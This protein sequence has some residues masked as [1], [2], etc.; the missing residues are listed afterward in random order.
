IMRRA[1]WH[2]NK[3][4][5]KDLFLYK[6][7]GFVIDLFGETYPELRENRS[8]IERIVQKEEKSYASTVRVGLKVLEDV[9][10]KSS[11]QTISGADV[12]KL[13]DTYGLRL[14]MVEYVAEQQGFRIDKEGFEARREQQSLANRE[15]W[16]GGAAKVVN[17][18]YRK[19]E[20]RSLF[21]GYTGTDLAGA[22]VT[23]LIKDGE[24]VEQIAA[25]DEAEV[26]LERTPFYAES[27]GQV[28]DTGILENDI[29]RLLVS[30]TQSPASGVIAHKVTVE[31]GKL[32]VGDLVDAHVD[33]E[34]RARTMANHTATHLLHAALREVLGLHVKQAGSLVAP[35][36]LRF[37]FTH[38]A[39][40][41]QEE[42]SEIERIVNDETLKNTVVTKE[43]KAFDEAVQGGAMALFGEKYSDRVRV[44]SVP[45]F[46]SELC[47]GT[48]VNATGDI[49]VFK[50]ISDASIASGTRR[51]EAVTGKGAYER[52][53]Q[54]ES[55]LAEAAA[56]LNTSP[57]TLPGEVE[58]LQTQ[59]REQQREIERLKL[60]LAQGATAPADEKVI[61]IDGI[62]VLVRKVD[63]LGKDGRRQLADTLS[64]RIAP[65]VVILG[66]VSNGSA[67]LVV[68]VSKD[69]TGRVQAGN[70]IRELTALSGK[71]GGGKPDLAEGGALPEKL[72][73]TL[74]AAPAIIEKML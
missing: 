5:L 21:T 59:L 43:E 39:P 63:N 67:S 38:F 65:G 74:Q 69:A 72:D 4:G 73:E 16:K 7:A 25:G 48:H 1:I 31:Q 37:D 52:F 46:S 40:L 2:G 35:D 15:S 27:G 56:R 53:Q 10:K 60:K 45:G 18:S 61:E 47:G 6:V 66:E 57:R 64:K 54:S 11:E 24:T 22:K 3:V 30:D 28:G 20:G 19:I 51:I 23:G 14:D 29:A 8:N 58:R 49:G 55:L 12:F 13:Y 70:V 41:T 32:K 9:M 44:V 62:K 36:R 68:M 26:V 33:A 50:I 34:K 71:K 42:I 17:P